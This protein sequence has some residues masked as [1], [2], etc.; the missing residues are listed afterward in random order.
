MNNY[1]EVETLVKKVEIGKAIRERQAN[2]EITEAYWNIGKLIVEAQGG[3]EKSKYGDALLKEWSKKLSK[4]YGKGYDYTNLSRFRQLYLYFPI[5]GPVGQQLNWTII[6][7]ILPIKD[8]NKRN[9]YINLC[10]KN[11]LSKRELIK[12]IKNNSYERLEHKP[13]KVDIIT[14]TNVPTITENFKNPILLNLNGNKVEN[15][16]NLEKLI[17]SQLSYVFMQLGNDFT[18]VGNQYKIS[19]GNKNY[20]IDMLLYNINYNCYVIVEIKCRTLKKEDKGQTEFYMTLV[21]KYKKR[22]NNNPTIGIII[23]R[24]QDKFVANFVKSEKLVPLTYELVN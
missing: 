20:Y 8:E 2:N 15:E 13:D 9:Y 3:K 18:W 4:E 10:I 14:S 12:E 5:V 23:T 24:E 21:D 11:N 17:Y 22:A 7:T 1:E 16:K 6:R 19:D